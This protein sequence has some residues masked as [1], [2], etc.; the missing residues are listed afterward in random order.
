M[1][2]LALLLFLLPASLHAQSAATLVADDVS[3]QNQS[4]LIA[5]GNINV[6]YDGTRLSAR[7]IVFD[8]TNDRLT[9]DGPIVIQGPGGEIITANRATLDP[10]LENGILQ[11]A[12]LVLNQQL[13]LAANQIDRAEGRYSQLYK[14]AVTSCRV[15]SGQA[16]LWEIRAER[17]IHDELERQLYFTNASFHVRGVP[18][19]W[20]PQ[21][22]LP[23]PTLERATGLLVPRIR[24]SNQLGVGIKLPYFIK[25]GDH[26]D[27]TLTPYLSAE[28]KT[29]EARYRQAFLRGDIEINAAIS[30]DT[31]QED[32]FRSYIFADGLFDIGRGFDLAFDIE[33]VSDP[34]YLLDYGFSSKD[35]LD[36]AISIIRARDTDL[37]Q[38]SFTYYQT[39][40]DDEVNNTLPPIV[41]DFSYEKRLFP[42]VGGTLTWNVSG[43]A[44]VRY[45]SDVGDAGRDVARLGTGVDW[46]RQ[47][48]SSAGLVTKAEAGVRLDAYRLRDA[49]DFDSGLRTAP[50]GQITFSYPMVRRRAQATQM[51]TPIVALG[52]SDSF[53]TT[54]PNEDSTRPEFDA[55]NLFARARFPGDDAVETGF[56]GAVG[57]QWARHGVR[58]GTA[59]L[60]FGRVYRE[61]INPDFTTTSG[62]QGNASDWLVAGQFTLPQGFRLEGRTQLG[63]KLAPTMAAVKIDWNTSDLTL[64]TSYLWQAADADLGRP[65][66]ISEWLLD[67]R[68]QVNDI[69]A[70]SF[71]TRYDVTEDSPVTA[72]LGVE[73]RNECV[74]VDLSVSRRYTSSTTVDPSTDYGLSVSLN[75]FS[76]GRSVAGP[77]RSCQK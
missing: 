8:Q 14:T 47:W 9:I 59:N 34:A 75:G 11:G 30:R 40:R 39:L 43:D 68:V 67:T 4:L 1:R 36:G 63:D 60:T 69:W 16:P 37:F 25:L 15:C 5:S 76:A 26:R 62:L 57:V 45:G 29:L 23:D 13:Q 6:F 55:A 10:Q 3:I 12:R 44:L 65:D 66:P 54:P 52:W 71:D 61:D 17:I 31:L 20:L 72:G 33:A 32:D 64:S 22:R 56:R 2:L 50:G 27:L 48:I 24:T 51:L 19:L 42:Q 21:A 7:R 18:I 38:T 46:Q 77:A 53:G 73:W 74:T 58:G 28:T 35:R 49:T 70:V 41:A